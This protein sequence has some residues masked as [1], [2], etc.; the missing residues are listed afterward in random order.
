MDAYNIL[1]LFY[2]RVVL[3]GYVLTQVV[4]IYGLSH[5]YE[6]LKISYVN[7]LEEKKYGIGNFGFETIWRPFFFYNLETYI[8]VDKQLESHAYSELW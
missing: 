2:S 4:F 5:H 3:P 7:F 6:L 1:C 8:V